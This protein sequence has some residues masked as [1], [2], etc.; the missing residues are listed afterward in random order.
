ML[1]GGFS[2]NSDIPNIHLISI[3]KYKTAK[4]QPPK[5][6]AARPRSA[7]LSALAM[8]GQGGGGMDARGESVCVREKLF[9]AGKG[10]VDPIQ[11]IFFTKSNIL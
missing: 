2:H 9:A 1:S 4:K 8:T 3:A 6:L 7:P 10:L 11:R 5:K